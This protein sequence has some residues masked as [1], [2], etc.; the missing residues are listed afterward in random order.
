M[1][2][3][4]MGARAGFRMVLNAENRLLA[5]LE[6]RHSAVVEVEMGHFNRF[7]HQ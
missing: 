7:R 1:M 4:I 6:G 2:I 3:R 5:M